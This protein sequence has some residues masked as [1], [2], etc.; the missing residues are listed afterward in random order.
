[1][2]TMGRGTEWDRSKIFNV[3]TW[4]MFMIK[5]N[6]EL[7]IKWNLKLKIPFVYCVH[8]IANII[9][10]EPYIL[11]T[12]K[13]KSP[14]IKIAKC[15][16]IFDTFMPSKWTFYLDFIIIIFIKMSFYGRTW[17]PGFIVGFHRSKYAKPITILKASV[18]TASLFIIYLYAY[19][20]EYWKY[21]VICNSQFLEYRFVAFK[22]QTSLNLLSVVIHYFIVCLRFFWV[23]AKCKNHFFHSDN[24]INIQCATHIFNSCMRTYIRISHVQ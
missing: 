1:M 18:L 5:P 16:N 17:W 13:A 8:S 21:T 4:T 22:M 9:R 12:C 2:E 10:L 15:A 23:L 3:K 20:E 11:K 6:L 24:K 19:V 14:K 7:I